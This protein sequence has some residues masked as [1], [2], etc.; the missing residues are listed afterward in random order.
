MERPQGY[1]RERGAYAYHDTETQAQR[2]GEEDITV[3]YA[4]ALLAGETSDDDIDA[5][6]GGAKDAS[7]RQVS[8]NPSAVQRNKAQGSRVAAGGKGEGVTHPHRSRGT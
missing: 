3:L 6:D 2:A 4:E 5:D 7:C 1:N 8:S